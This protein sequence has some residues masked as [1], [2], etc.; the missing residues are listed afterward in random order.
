M[1]EER[2]LVAPDGSPV[3]VDGS[4]TML[5]D[6]TES[7]LLVLSLCAS[8]AAHRGESVGAPEADALFAKCLQ[9]HEFDSDT[10]KLGRYV[11]GVKGLVSR[12]VATSFTAPDGG[13]STIVVQWGR[14]GIGRQTIRSA[15]TTKRGR[16]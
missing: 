3:S 2:F 5:G 13:A 10:Q 8:A 16:A 11:E 4:V 9:R 12:G 6:L 1:A 15:P 14:V 7:E